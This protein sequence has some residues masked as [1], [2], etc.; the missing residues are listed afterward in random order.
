MLSL[1]EIKQRLKPY[2]LR[3]L[4]TEVGIEYNMLWRA[5]RKEK[6]VKYEVVKQLSDYL[7]KK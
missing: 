2:N 1:D 7:Q 6:P 5:I 4:S 3:A